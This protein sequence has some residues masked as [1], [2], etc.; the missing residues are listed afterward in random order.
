[1]RTRRENL[2]RRLAN[3]TLHAHIGAVALPL[4]LTL[5]SINEMQSKGERCGLGSSSRL[6]SLF[7]TSWRSSAGWATT[8][9][10]ADLAQVVEAACADAL[11]AALLGDGATGASLDTLTELLAHHLTRSGLAT[12]PGQLTLTCGAMTGLGLATANYWAITQTMLPGV[13]PG[14]VAGIQN[15]SLNLA[16]IVAPLLTGWLKQVTG[17]YTAPMQTIWVFLIIGV[18]AYLFLAR[19]PKSESTIAFALPRKSQI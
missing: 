8:A 1:M 10:P 12:R 3:D 2:R 17:G 4:S 11:P 13:A 14:R 15:T 16:G 19:E 18:G 9:G 6:N 7:A 5:L